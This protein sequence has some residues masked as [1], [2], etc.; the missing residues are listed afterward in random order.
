MNLGSDPIRIL[1]VSML[2]TTSS[3]VLDVSFIRLQVSA[4]SVS[5]GVKPEMLSTRQALQGCL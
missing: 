1:P 2:D 5:A 3:T 4:I